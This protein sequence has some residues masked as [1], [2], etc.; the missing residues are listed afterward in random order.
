LDVRRM[1]R[2][3]RPGP[4]F[5]WPALAFVIAYGIAI[6]PIVGSGRSGMLGYAM[7]DDPA[8]HIAH[9][10]QLAQHDAHQHHPLEDSFHA[11]TRDLEAGYPLGGYAW[12]LFGRVMTGV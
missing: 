12:P 5:L 2:L 9:V 8:I 10:E 6:A 3:P 11:A 1:G 4:A 7:Y